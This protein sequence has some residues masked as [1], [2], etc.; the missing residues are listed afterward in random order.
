[1]GNGGIAGRS[2]ETVCGRIEGKK[3]ELRTFPYAIKVPFSRARSPLKLK[4][5]LAC[6]LL[7][8][9]LR[10]ID[11]GAATSFCKQHLQSSGS[12]LVAA[13]LS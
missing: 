10:A 4:V 11:T 12:Y 6:Y 3:Q 5:L 1:M 13:S 2:T 7:H 8:R 9:G